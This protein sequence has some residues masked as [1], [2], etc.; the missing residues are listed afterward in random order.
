[1]P[2]L[3]VYGQLADD[4]PSVFKVTC[5]GCRSDFV[6]V[7]RDRHNTAV[8]RGLIAPECPGCRSPLI[9]NLWPWK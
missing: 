7:P 9:E 6:F 4:C 3:T 2:L 5:R 8:V 1:M